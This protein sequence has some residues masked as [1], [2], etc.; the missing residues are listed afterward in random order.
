MRVFDPEDSERNQPQGAIAGGALVIAG[1][2]TAELL[3]AGKQVLHPMAQPIQCPLEGAGARLV[4]LARDGDPNPAL[5]ADPAD[6]P[7][8]V[9]LVAGD[10]SRTEARTAPTQ[11][12]HGALGQQP[13][14]HR[15]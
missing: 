10:P 5:T 14:E 3:A 7:A 11:T 9:A 15:R 6:G 4:G 12:P 1:G 8:A 2:Q 13:W